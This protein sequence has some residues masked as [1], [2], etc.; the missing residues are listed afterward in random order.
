[1]NYTIVGGG[2]A[3]CFALK[4]I[5]NYDPDSHV[6][7]ISAEEHCFY[8]RPMTPLVIKGDKER[9]EILYD[10]HI[11]E[12]HMIHGQ[13]ASLNTATREITLENGET[14]SFD[15]LLI[16]TGSAPE[17]PGLPGIHEKNVH[18]L[19]TMKDAHDLKDAAGK[20]KKAIILGGG[21]VGI[22]KAMALNHAGLEVTVIEQLDHILLPRLDREGAEIMAGKLRQEGIEIITNTTI[23]EILPDAKGVQLSSGENLACDMV[24]VAV[25]VRPNIDWLAGSGL[26]RDKALVVDEKMQ[27]SVEG[28]YAA[29]DVVET[30]DCVTGKNIVSALWANAVEMGKVAGANM[31]GG[32]VKYPGSLEVLNATEIERIAMISAGDILAQA[33]N[34]EVVI[35]RT[36]DTYRKLVFQ[37]D[38]LTGAVFLGDVDRAGVYTS[39]IKTGAPIGPLKDKIIDGTLTYLD[40][41]YQDHGQT[42]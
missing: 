17:V 34:S 2:I 39:L 6:T 21:L 31:A 40:Y 5:K 14:V 25:G 11:P 10:D 9:D 42:S 27:T 32:K 37:D 3:A 22:K 13:A 35:R 19:R 38:V 41:V 26:K 15:R 23:T 24:C 1:M 28:I 12:Y 30:V 20:A 4:E 29:G 8:Y 7:V 16:A 36:S 18:Y 33:E